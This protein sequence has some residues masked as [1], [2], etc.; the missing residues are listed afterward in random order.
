[1][2]LVRTG[3]DRWEVID[4][5][6]R[7]WGLSRHP[8]EGAGEPY[9]S[10][11]SHDE[12]LYRLIH[13]IEHAHRQVLFRAEAGLGKT[14]VLRRAIAETRSP[15][16]RMVLVRPMGED[17]QL[18]ALIAGRLGYRPGE[19]LGWRAMARALRVAT[20]QG[21]RIV[22]AIDDWSAD[23]APRM[24]HDLHVLGRS[25]A[26][27]TVIQVGRPSP[28]GDPEAGDAWSLGITLRRLTRAQVESYL[29]AKLAAA[30]CQDRVFTPRA[31]TRL[32]GLSGG[33]PRGIDHLAAMSLMAGAARGLEV[34][35]PEVVDG[36]AQEF[37]EVPS[38]FG[39]WR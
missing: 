38:H 11:P 35:P 36:V 19:G 24:V 23:L 22:L 3:P 25:E 16:R 6:Y 17:L 12:A 31:V 4:V 9:V 37:R 8:F 5:W 29:D 33:I 21:T 15:D 20:L 39:P 34:L 2:R 18:P 32:H 1:M 13:A 28:G 30:G 14:T 10:L 26:G 7:H 27:L